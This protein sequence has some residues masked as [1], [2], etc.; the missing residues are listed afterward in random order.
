M[1]SLF[2]AVFC[3]VTMPPPKAQPAMSLW[4]ISD[5]DAQMSMPVL[6]STLSMM[7]T[8]VGGPAAQDRLMPW[9][10]VVCAAG[11]ENRPC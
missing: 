9:F 7:C 3:S 4:L 6:V 1:V 5:D 10:C 11:S 8:A 2:D